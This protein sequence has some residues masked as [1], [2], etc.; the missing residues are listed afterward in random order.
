MAAAGALQ[1]GFDEAYDIISDVCDTLDTYFWD[2]TV[3]RFWDEFNSDWTP[4]STYRGMNANM[5]GAEALLAAHEA[6]GESHY[7]DWAGQILDFVGF[8][9]PQYIGAFQNIMTI[10]TSICIT[11]EIRCSAFWYDAGSFV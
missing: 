7:L 2:E 5:H 4:F 1:A 6:T 10:G 3:G 8:I 9:A 11:K